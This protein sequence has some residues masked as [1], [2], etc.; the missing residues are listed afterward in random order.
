MALVC[1][2]DVENNIYGHFDIVIRKFCLYDQF[3][4]L[5]Y[6][7]R[8]PV[9]YLAISDNGTDKPQSHGHWMFH[10]LQVVFSREKQKES[11]SH[12][13]VDDDIS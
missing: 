8:L 10:R 13:I 4:S 9:V 5:T 6:T 7:M 12:Q 2:I 1:F 11:L 3:R